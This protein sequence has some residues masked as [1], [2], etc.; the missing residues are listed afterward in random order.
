MDERR[1]VWHHADEARRRPGALLQRP[2]RQAR[3]DRDDELA[4]ELEAGERVQRIARLHAKHEH[5]CSRCHFAVSCDRSHASVAREPLGCFRHAVRHQD[6]SCRH[7]AGLHDALH[8]RSRHFA[9]ADEAD[10]HEKVES[11]GL[12]QLTG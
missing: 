11:R 2:Q 5:V 4:R 1:R 9:G 3:H 7:D 8:E 12:E 6:I 10:S